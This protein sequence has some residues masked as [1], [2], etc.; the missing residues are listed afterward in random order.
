MLTSRLVR[1]VRGRFHSPRRRT[2]EPSFSRSVGV[3]LA[4]TVS[5]QAIS[6][7]LSPI[8]TRLFSPAQFGDLGVYSSVLAILVTISSLGLELA[9]PICLAEAECANLLALCWISM[10]AITALVGLLVWQI[11]SPL[12]NLLAQGSIASYSY[13]LP[14]GL[15]WL[16]GYY[17]MLAVA[18]RASAFTDI[19]RTRLSQ[20]ISGPTSQIALG[21]LGAGTPGLVLGYLIGQSSGTLLLLMRFVFRRRAWL[22][23]ISWRGMV[24]VGKRYVNFPLYASWS[25]LLD[26]A[27]SGA[28]LFVL[29]SAC[30]SPTIAGFMFLSERVIV[31]PLLMVTTSLLQ[32]FTGEAGRAVSQDPPQLRRRFRQVVS[33]QFLL[34]V[35]WIVGANLVAGYAIPLLFGA[36]WADAIPYLRALSL[37]YLV[38]VIL[39][40]VSSTLQ[41]LERQ[42]MAAVWQICRLALVIASIL[43]PWRLGMS[44]VAAL[45]ICSLV[46][47]VC[48]LVL[49]AMMAGLVDEHAHQPRG[50]RPLRDNKVV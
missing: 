42:A 20:G 25:R 6:L 27:G 33:G 40:P 3:M 39:H 19:A 9:I 14:I 5:G 45:W 47:S 31:R 32:V 49:L 30:Y 12:L 38:G 26:A 37:S 7:L 15:V 11:P 48:C 29:V 43:V 46:Q 17:I 16:G 8:L 22:R 50:V 23:Q 21:L 34:A 10:A 28:I 4:G 35:A 13:L 41:V 44:A 2:G 24:A 36:A 1:A 18:T